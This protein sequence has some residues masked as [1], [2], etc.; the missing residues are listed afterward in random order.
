M[1]TIAQSAAV[2]QKPK[3]RSSSSR[4]RRLWNSRTL[5]LMCLPAIAFFLI[6]AYLPMPG[7]YL[8]FIKYNYTR[9][10]FQKPVHR[11]R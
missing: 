4:F 6:F 8:A 7:L 11:I 1:R 3:L 5:F 9:R 2:I 10:N